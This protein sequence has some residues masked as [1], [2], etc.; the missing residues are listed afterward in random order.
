MKKEDVEAKVLAQ[1]E[2]REAFEEQEKMMKR[3]ERRKK[4]RGP[5]GQIILLPLAGAEENPT[6]LLEILHQAT[7]AADKKSA[8]KPDASEPT[9]ARSKSTMN[10]DKSATGKS[11]KTGSTGMRSGRRRRRVCRLME[12]CMADNQLGWLAGHGLAKFIMHNNE[13]LTAVDVS[14]NSMGTAGMM[15]VIVALEECY[16]MLPKLALKVD[17]EV[18]LYKGTEDEGTFM[19]PNKRL[20]E[21]KKQRDMALAKAKKKADREAKEREL[22]EQKA[23]NTQMQLVQ[24]RQEAQEAMEAGQATAAQM[25]LLNSDP[26]AN[27][28]GQQQ[29]ADGMDAGIEAGQGPMVAGLALVPHAMTTHDLT[30]DAQSA[31]SGDGDMVSLG[32]GSSQEDNSQLGQGLAQRQRNTKTGGGMGGSVIAKSEISTQPSVVANGQGQGRGGGML[33]AGLEQSPTKRR[34]RLRRKIPLGSNLIYL[35]IARNNLGPPVATGMTCPPINHI[36][37]HKYTHIHILL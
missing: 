26:H 17:K 14:A 13:H 32:G 20:K 16:G 36:H 31:L 7:A 8:K 35:N 2:A 23:Y 3:E 22:A 9:S 29:L 5:D 1:E 25:E 6:S 27:H 21:L 30:T 15:P 28:Q 12:L 33:G 37:S 24:L 11:E 10:D 34:N 4:I 19:T 18:D